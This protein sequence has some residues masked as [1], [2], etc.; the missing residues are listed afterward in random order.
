MKKAI[1]YYRVSTKRQGH[2]GLGLD[3]QKKVIKD[4]ADAHGY[5]VVREFVEIESGKKNN[6]AKLIQALEMCATED[7]T[8]LVANIDRLSRNLAFVA[9][10]MDARTD[11]IAVDD[12]H[13][14]ELITHIKAAIAQDERKRISA[15]TI[16]AL[17]AAKAKGVELGYNGRYVL[18][19]KNKDQAMQFAQTMKPV[20]E[21]LKSRGITSIRK[22]AKEL[23]RLKVPTYQND[24]SKWHVNSVHKLLQRIKEQ[25]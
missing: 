18:S 23:N 15:R 10:L 5:I 22:I 20:I 21:K 25:E 12:P 19:Q 7:A 4:F 17:Q 1:A 24:G 9:G 6:R 3:A 13:A 11:F 16:A 8:L 14:S 2:S